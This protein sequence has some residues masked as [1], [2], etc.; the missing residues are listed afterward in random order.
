MLTKVCAH[1]ALRLLPARVGHMDVLA[2]P[3]KR[4]PIKPALNAGA[5]SIR[6]HLARKP[7][8]R[9]VKAAVASW[10]GKRRA[11]PASKP[12]WTASTRCPRLPTHDHGWWAT[13][14]QLRNQAQKGTFRGQA[15]AQGDDL[16]KHAIKGRETSSARR[17]SSAPVLKRAGHRTPQDPKPGPIPMARGGPYETPPPRFKWPA[18]DSTKVGQARLPAVMLLISG[19]GG[20]RPRRIDDGHQT[21]SGVGRSSGRRPW[22]RRAAVDDRASAV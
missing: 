18:P 14:R 15:E 10:V 22:N 2:G 9:R 21:V 1:F 20:P 17:S 4:Q 16:K 7:S 8:R 3:R 12:R 13:E 6:G 5:Q 19:S 11:G